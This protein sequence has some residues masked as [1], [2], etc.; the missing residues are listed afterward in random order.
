LVRSRYHT[1]VA[2]LTRNFEEKNKSI[3]VAGR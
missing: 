1:C 2:L 3:F